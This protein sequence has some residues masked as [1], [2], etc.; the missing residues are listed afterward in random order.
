M[1]AGFDFPSGVAAWIPSALEPGLPS[2]TAHN[3]RCVGGVRD[4]STVAQ[5]RARTLARL[6]TAS[7][8]PTERG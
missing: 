6:L 2:R 8:M 7:E 3:W 4:G 1:P 5:A